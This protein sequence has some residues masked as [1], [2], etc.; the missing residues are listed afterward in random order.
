[1]ELRRKTKTA[2]KL[3]RLVARTL[4]RVHLLLV[5]TL[6]TLAA[7]LQFHCLFCFLDVFYILL[8]V[9]QL[10]LLVGFQ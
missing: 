2:R 4:L 1:M 9:R 8:T 6:F 5:A 3:R 7:V 10:V